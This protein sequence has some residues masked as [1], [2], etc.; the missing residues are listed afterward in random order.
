MTGNCFEVVLKPFLPMET[1]L[2]QLVRYVHRNPVRAGIADRLDLYRWSSHVGY[3]LV[4][5]GRTGF[6]RTSFTPSSRPR[7]NGRTAAYRRFMALEDQEDITRILDGERWPPLLGDKSSLNR[8]K[9][10]FFEDKTHRRAPDSKT[11]A[12]EASQI[13]QADCSYARL[14]ES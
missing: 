12:P 13:M 6:T 10:R 2:L 7:K 4:Q 14:D 8:L 9:A 3:L 11:L 5:A 1:L